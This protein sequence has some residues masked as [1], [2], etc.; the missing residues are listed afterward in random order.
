MIRI[1]IPAFA[2]MFL[3]ACG[4]FQESAQ[5]KTPTPDEIRM[6]TAIRRSNADLARTALKNG[7]NPNGAMRNGVP[8]LIAA[9]AKQ[10]LILVEIL[11]ENGADPNLADEYGE[12]ALHASAASSKTNVT[13]MLLKHGANPNA[14]GRYKRTPLMEAARLGKVENAK[15]LLENGADPAL[16][17]SLGRSVLCYAALA[18][19]NG[20]D[21]LLL[22]AGDKDKL[23]PDPLDLPNS[24]LLTAMRNGQPDTAEFLLRLVPDF[25]PGNFQ[26]LGQAAMR[27][28]I[29]QNR[30]NWVKILVERGVD[31]NKSLPLAFKAVRLISVEGVYKFLARNDVI[32]RGYTPLMWAAIYSRPQIAE[33][34]VLQGSDVSAISNEGRD[35]LDYAND[36]ATRSAIRS[37][38]R[39]A[40]KPVKQTPAETAEK[41]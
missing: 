2:L 35:A 22:F 31:L 21:V 40:G 37:A 41:K 29:D 10:E 23:T 3:T 1:L 14:P 19:S 17:D 38:G 12:T 4:I 36:T 28:A 11:L 24:P 32:D 15:L 7:V 26:P 34:L 33:Y 9:A 25:K 39:K 18:P 6:E 27:I 13:R 20:K 5:K 30:L 16:R 8:F